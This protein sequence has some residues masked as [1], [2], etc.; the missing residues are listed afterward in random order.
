MTSSSQIRIAFLTRYLPAPSETFVLDEA[1]A[2]E[3]AGAEVEVW[4]LGRLPRAVCHG[5]H[6]EL[7]DRAETAPR[8]S[9][10]RA[11]LA[12]LAEGE[13]PI[14]SAV[15]AAWSGAGRARDL[16][17]ASWLARRWRTLRIDVVRVHHAAEGARY[18]V[19]AGAMAGIPVSIAVHARDLFVPLPDFSWITS[20]ASLITTITPFHRD[21]LLRTG[22]PS[23]RVALLP[24]PVRVPSAVALPPEPGSP[25]RLLAVG[26]LVP[27][28]GHDLLLA[29]CEMLSRDGTPIELTIVGDGA[30]GLALRH[31]AS[32]M[33]QESGGLLGIEMLGAVPVER[34]EELLERGRYHAAVLACREAPDGDRDGI[35]V[36][37]LEAQARG[38]PVVTT[39]M[40]G[41]EHELTGGSGAV[42]VPAVD[43]DGRRE[44]S[45]PRFAR[46]LAELY[47]DPVGR[48]GQAEAARRVA[49]GRITPEQIGRRL[50]DLLAPLAD[51]RTTTDTASRGPIQELQR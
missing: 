16:R 12:G 8:P 10:I 43:R 9:S 38:V 44:P 26:R 51:R 29:A 4:A 15:R 31:L 41:F 46:A 33:E 11:V 1:L 48:R 30:E 23:E 20:N 17:R 42:L 45:L 37:L 32:R 50:L 19:A 6:R 3:A 28:K 25:L 49:E 13:R 14:S 21:R 22:L 35:P 36:A 39:A 2:L 40:P 7:H 47:R 24:C 18:A 34:V 27:K 5:R